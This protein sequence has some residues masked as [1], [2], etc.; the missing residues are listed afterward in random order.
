MMANLFAYKIKEKEGS[1]IKHIPVLI[2][3]FS[4]VMITTFIHTAQSKAA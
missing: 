4:F 3:L 1:S 2:L